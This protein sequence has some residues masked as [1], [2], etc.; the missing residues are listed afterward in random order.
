MKHAINFL[1]S[2]MK[3]KSVCNWIYS[4]KNRLIYIKTDGYDSWNADSTMAML[5]LPI[6]KDIRD[7]RSEWYFDVKTAVKYGLVD[8][9][10]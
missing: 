2:G 6:L 5:I 8:E 10:L 7:K 3:D 9:I 1:G 4:K